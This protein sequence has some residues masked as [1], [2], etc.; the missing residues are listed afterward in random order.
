M[1]APDNRKYRSETAQ[2]AAR[3]AEAA[4]WTAGIFALVVASLV[5]INHVQITAA[6]PLKDEALQAM[7]KKLQENPDQSDL[8][9][10]IRAYDLLARRAF[11]T[12]RAQVKLGGYLLL[13][14]IVVFLAGAKTAAELR[15][16]WPL[17]GKCPGPG[18]ARGAARWAVAAGGAAVAITAL[19]L[20]FVSPPSDL[21]DAR[22]E[23]SGPAAP[24]R[25]EARPFCAPEP[26]PDHAWPQ[27]RGPGGNGHAQHSDAP[28]KWNGP[29]G[30]G[31]KWKTPVPL[32]AH[33][34]PVVWEN[35]VFLT[36]SDKSTREVYCFDADT[37]TMVWKRQLKDVPGSP[38]TPPEVMESTGY[39]APTAATDGK[40]VFVI[41]AT[42]DAAAFAMDGTPSWARN[43]GAPKNPYGHA[44]SLVFFPG[45]LI[46]QYDTEAGG[47]LLA[48]DPATGKTVWDQ[49]R[50][51][52]IS[53]ATPIIVNTGTRMEV[54]LNSKPSL[55]AHDPV[56]GRLLWSVNHLGADGEVAPSPAYAAGMVFAGTEYTVMAAV[57][58]LPQPAIVWKH[59]DDLPD[60]SSPAA[61]DKYLIMAS[62]GGVVTC[63]EAATGK[64]FWREEFKEGFYS[65]PVI[66][67]DRVY[68]TDKA[69]ITLVF[70]LSER[71]EELARNALGEKVNCTPAFPRGRIFIRGEKHLYCIGR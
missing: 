12:S 45:R 71:Y 42:G 35:R 23:P 2:T 59:E 65:S 56:T 6:D 37:G 9:E 34:S 41:F 14:A 54:V 1:E 63:L 11:F 69:G 44:S 66:V 20:T 46:I 21:L 57:R 22:I 60:V 55:A 61:T 13:G 33:N 43:L 10:K 7:R 3:A 39:A 28:L 15:R 62:S 64:I 68:L 25:E 50:P 52:K 40:R 26:A 30:E 19:F 38:S 5:I 29:A 48:L 17:P 24:A 53:W 70:R 36:G 67:G 18:E 51:T 4:A 47:R 32:T 31:I 49:A 27:F 58:L 8:R 16:R